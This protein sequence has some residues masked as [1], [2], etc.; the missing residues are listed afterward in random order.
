AGCR[1]F[2][3]AALF[4]FVHGGERILDVAQ[5]LE[6]GLAVAVDGLAQA[7]Q[8][9]RVGGRRWVIHVYDFPAFFQREAQALAA[10]GEHE[11]GAVAVRK[12][13]RGAAAG[14]AEDPL[15]LVESQRPGC[16]LE[17]PGELLD[18]VG[19]GH[20]NGLK[21]TLTSTIAG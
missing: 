21:L 12:E 18:G 2:L 1:E 15:V 5:L 4:D 6:E 14:G 17:L 19:A 13:A 7:Q 3:E 16:D 11:P 10:Q 9:A 20:G 8:L